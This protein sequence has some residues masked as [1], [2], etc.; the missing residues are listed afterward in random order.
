MLWKPIKNSCAPYSSALAA[1]Y[2]LLM[3]LFCNRSRGSELDGLR[4]Q[5]LSADGSSV[6]VFFSLPLFR[7]SRAHFFNFSLVLQL[8]SNRT[9][10]TECVNGEGLQNRGMTDGLLT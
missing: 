1:H 6:E 2:T 9:L 7:L 3:P 8:F 10:N 5:S 4:R